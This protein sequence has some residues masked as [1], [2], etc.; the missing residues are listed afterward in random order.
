MGFF[1]KKKKDK[2]NDV[3]DKPSSSSQ[4]P[5]AEPAAVSKA[6]PPE[7]STDDD[8]LCLANADGAP[9]ADGRAGARRDVGRQTAALEPATP[10]GVQ[11]GH[12]VVCRAVS[13][14][15]NIARDTRGL[16]E[17]VRPM[18]EVKTVFCFFATEN[19]Q[20]ALTAIA[21]GKLNPHAVASLV[22]YHLRDVSEPICT[23][24]LRESILSAAGLS[25]GAERL[26]ELR[27][28][29]GRLPHQNR[30]LLASIGTMVTAVAAEHD[31]CY[32]DGIVTRMSALGQL[33]GPLFLRP[34]SSK[35]DTEMAASVTFAQDIF[36]NPSLLS[37]PISP[38]MPP[39]SLLRLPSPSPLPSPLSQLPPASPIALA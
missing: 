6:G 14:L 17:E 24:A 15:T 12:N 2:D 38:L 35:F 22:V 7:G 33:F 28:L 18:S 26:A 37:L 32:Q 10:R 5:R 1:K 34:N 20:G 30:Q 3:A 9:A 39:P 27:K 23:K 11:E 8:P 29:C 25:K 4:P 19:G 16:F 13:C 31:S 21:D 36:S